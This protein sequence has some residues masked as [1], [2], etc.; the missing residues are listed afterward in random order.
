[1]LTSADILLSMSRF[2]YKITSLILSLLQSAES[3]FVLVASS[4][5]VA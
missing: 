2:V 5:M 3:K 4:V 1:V